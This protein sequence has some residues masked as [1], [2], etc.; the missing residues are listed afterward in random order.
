MGGG[1]AL[2]MKRKSGGRQWGA[3]EIALTEAGEAE[4]PA[5]TDCCM[6]SFGGRDDTSCVWPGGCSYPSVLHGQRCP[7]NTRAG[8]ELGSGYS[9]PDERQGSAGLCKS[10]NQNTLIKPIPMSNRKSLGAGRVCVS[11]PGLSEHTRSPDGCGHR[12]IP[13]L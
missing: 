9:W 10:H 4:G 1:F 12:P 2:S 5:L 6:C 11:P 8:Q 7:G 3:V 13:P